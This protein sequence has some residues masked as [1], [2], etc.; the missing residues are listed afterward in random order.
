MTEHLP[1]SRP[2]GG[3]LFAPLLVG[4]A[5]ALGRHIAGDWYWPEIHAQSPFVLAFFSGLLITFAFRPVLLRVPWSRPAAM[6]MGLGILLGAGPAADWCLQW[7]IAQGAGTRM[8]YMLAPTLWA[9]LLGALAAAAAMGRLLRPPGGSVGFAELAGRLAIRTRRQWA[10]R[11]GLLALAGVAVWLLFGW[12][13]VLFADPARPLFV[14]LVSPNPWLQAL[15]QGLEAG[16]GNG[17]GPGAH[18]FAWGAA[19]RVLGLYG[20]R[21]LALCLALVPIA[22][23]VRGR[24]VQVTLVFSLLLFI[25]GDFAPLMLDQPYP[26]TVWLLTRT[27]LGA[28]RAALLGGLAAALIGRVRA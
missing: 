4:L 22:L 5:Y 25:V 2:L 7:L 17:A 21:A 26:S 27:A 13:D 23:V 6:A 15:G 20:L 28:L 16:R 24:W 14:P 18:A 9:E 10:A 12:L 3:F 11:L 8:P 1:Q 19:A